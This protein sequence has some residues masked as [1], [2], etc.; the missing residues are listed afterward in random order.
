MVRPPI[1]GHAYGRG[2]GGAHTSGSSKKE[3]CTEVGMGLDGAGVDL[4]TGVIAGVDI[5]LRSLGS[6]R[7]AL[8]ALP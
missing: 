1:K 6:L 3:C 4:T 8:R 2:A 5:R 7:V